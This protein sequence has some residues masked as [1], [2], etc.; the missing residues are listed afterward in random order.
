MNE[1]VNVLPWFKRKKSPNSSRGGSKDDDLLTSCRERCFLNARAYFSS[2]KLTDLFHFESCTVQVPIFPF[3][4]GG[5]WVILSIVFASHRESTDENVLKLV[6]S[7][8]CVLVKKAEACEPSVKDVVCKN[9]KLYLLRFVLKDM[10]TILDVPSEYSSLVY[11][12]ADNRG[13]K[14]FVLAFSQKFVLSQLVNSQ[15]IADSYNE[16]SSIF[17]KGRRDILARS[18]VIQ[19]KFLAPINEL[20]RPN[21]A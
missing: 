21:E 9:V 17:V 19:L 13:L 4:F 5:S 14:V 15:D 11:L 6:D 8:N 18:R 20:V 16:S 12:D 3:E 1:E 10:Y 2:E 7:S